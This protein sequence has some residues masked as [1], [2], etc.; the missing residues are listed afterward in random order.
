MTTAPS[1][2][3]DARLVQLA[4]AG[5]VRAFERL[6]ER[7]AGLVYTIARARLGSHEM[8]EDLVQEVFL[9]V[10]L[11]IHRLD[12]PHKLAPWLAR[13]ARNLAIDWQRRGLRR[14]Q[15]VPMVSLDAQEQPL[16]VPDTQTQGVRETMEAED[17]RRA[18]QRAIDRLPPDQREVVL[19]HYSEGMKQ[20]EIA[21]RLGVRPNRVHRLL[22]R[23]LSA[24]RGTVEPTLREAAP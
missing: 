8:A 24:M 3:S 4:R 5:D 16:Q 23:G 19:L 20:V 22:R 7:H 17:Q 2:L 13:L 9:R 18:V 10:H 6:I 1:H 11:N 15:I 12:D 14:S 21:E